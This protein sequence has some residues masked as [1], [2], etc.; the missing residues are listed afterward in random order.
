MARLNKKTSITKN[1]ARHPRA[2]RNYEGALAFTPDLYTDVTLRFASMLMGEKKFYKEVD[3]TTGAV[4]AENQ[5]DIFLKQIRTMLEHDPEYVLKLAVFARHELYLRQAP[6][7]ALVEASLHPKARAFVRAAGKYVLKRPDQ[8][9]E[10]LAY[11]IAVN[12]NIGNQDRDASYDKTED[13]NL[14][15]SLKMAFRDKLEYMR[16]HDF[17]KYLQLDQAIKLRDVMKLA[18]PNPHRRF[19]VRECRGGECGIPEH[20][21]RT[22]M[23]KSVIENTIAPA[24]TWNSHM[25]AAGS[26]HKPTKEDWQ[27]ALKK[28]PIFALVRNLRN[29]LEN[30]VEM[31]DAI[32]LLTKPEAIKGS[33]MFPFRFYEAW[34]MIK[35]QMARKYDRTYRS[36]RITKV[37]LDNHPQYTDVLDALQTAMDLAVENIPTIPGVTAIFADNSGSMYQDK[38]SEYTIIDRATAAN[39]AM[40]VAARAC[41]KA[42][43]FVFAENIKRVSVSKRDGVLT[44]VKEIAQVGRTVGSSTF[45]YKTIE[46]LSKEGI[47]VDRIMPVSDFQM[48]SETAIRSVGNKNVRL[49]DP[50]IYGWSTGHD[51][52]MFAAE[53]IKYKRAHPQTYLYP[54]DMAGYGSMQV[55]QDD[56]TIC[57]LG[58]FT[59]AIFRFVP[60]FEGNRQSMIDYIK[61]I[62]LKKYD[63]RKRWMGQQAGDEDAAE[64]SHAEE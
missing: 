1:L 10:A 22:I 56:K 55:P 35:E 42:H 29:L 13:H 21:S 12:G 46:L 58:G 49:N 26:K 64:A 11:L 61:S 4:E 43:L 19:G 32:E 25:I 37:N 34:Y 15:H 44:N 28:M 7:V 33:M 40:A 6:T 48:Y 2:T 45:G 23:F 3:P 50:R 8:M 53:W 20:N 51:Q 52:V 62:D 17:A 57:M 5:D 41:E 59:D 24:D 30:K 36:M 63:A 47:E 31:A 18:Y 16:E 39:V 38:L 14:P 27:I 9:A 60:F 54:V